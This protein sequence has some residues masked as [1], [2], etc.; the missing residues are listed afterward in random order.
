MPRRYGHPPLVA[1]FNSWR[2]CETSSRRRFRE[3]KHGLN[4]PTRV[5]LRRRRVGGETALLQLPRLAARK[6]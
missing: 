5:A 2:E 4:L 3:T 6:G 1:E